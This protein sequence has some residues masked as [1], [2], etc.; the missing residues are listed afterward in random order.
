MKL[1]YRGLLFSKIFAFTPRAHATIL[2]Y[3]HHSA[4]EQLRQKRAHP[5][6]SSSFE[7]TLH[8][9]A[10]QKDCSRAKD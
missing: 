2:L 4:K 8:V 9:V 5:R 3:D 10:R 1:P 6:Q 7:M